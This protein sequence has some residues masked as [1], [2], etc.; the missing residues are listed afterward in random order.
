LPATLG[1]ARALLVEC[2]RQTFAIPFQ[3]IK[4]ILRLNPGSMDVGPGGVQ[5]DIGNRLIPLI[6]L[7]QYLQIANSKDPFDATRPLLI[8]QVGQ[9][10]V[11][12]AVDRI[13]CG[14]DIVIKTLGNHLKRVPGLIGATLRG[15]GTVIAILDPNDLVGQGA[16]AP[17]NVTRSTEHR[18][19][20]RQKMAMV[21][22]DSISVRRVTANLLHSHGWN[23]VTAIDGI[24]ALEKLSNLENAPDIFLCDMEMPRMDGIELI[25]QIRGQNEFKAT[26]IV[27]VTSRSSEKH[28]HK[29]IDAGAT[30]YVVKP[31]NDEKLLELVGQ[32][33][34]L[35]RETVK[36]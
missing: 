14:Q 23:V 6:D 34:Q 7:G 1:V 16:C 13:E 22:D 29:A 12:V 26:P 17:E 20:G 5:V 32:L 35:T 33:V 24:D 30:E 31:F 3:S 21:I 10:E 2:C 9:D 11:A 36:A 8:V 25:R 28:R 27:M 18:S 15:D 4:Q 19:P